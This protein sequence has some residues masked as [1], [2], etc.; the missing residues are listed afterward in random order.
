MSEPVDRPNVL[1]LMSDQHSPH[2]LGAYGNDLVRTPHLDRLAAEGMRFTN[3]CCAA[4]LCVPS[5]MSFMTSRTPSRN[6]VWNNNHVLSSNVPTWAHALGAVGYETALIGR[7][8]F[9]GADQRHGFEKRPIGEFMAHHPGVPC[10]GGP[11]WQK[12][13]GATTGQSREC[14]EIAGKGTT[15]YQVMDRQVAEAACDYL[16]AHA[17]D[18]DGRPFAAVAGFLLPHCPFIGPKDLFDYYYERID[19]PPI[20]GNQPETVRRFRRLRGIL[21][22]PLDDERI[23][24][25]RAAYFAVCEFFDGLVGR[26][27]DSLDETGLA[28]STLVLYVSDHG[29]CAGEHGCWWKSNYYG[30][31]VGVPMIARMPGVVPAGAVQPCVC[32]LMDVGPTL[33]EIAGAEMPRIDGRSLW[34]TLCGRHPDDWS[35]ETFSELVD[36]RGADPPL[37]SRMVRSGPWKLWFYGDAEGLP[38][39]LFNLEDDPGEINDL[40]ADPAF[41]DVREGLLARVHEGWDPAEATRATVEQMRDL[42][43]LAAWGR[44]VRPPCEDTLPFPPPEAEADVEL[45]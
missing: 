24:V 16:K 3:A 26:I 35:D 39:A 42:E 5:R 30:S 12:Y 45:L 15:A 23:R 28:R 40:G 44:A 20:E 33:A 36:R 13:S 4:P 41:A 11:P 2:L 19:I 17:A 8:H 10:V 21:D 6:R 43:V 29:E 14:V 25:A 1:I 34:P 37:P 22:P 18:D 9:V 27:L 38:P 32:N 7:M 31:S